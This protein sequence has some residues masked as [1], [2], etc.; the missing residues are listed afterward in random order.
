MTF[1]LEPDLDMVKMYLYTKNEVPSF[2][3]SKGIVWTDTQIDTQSDTQTN[4]Q[5]SLSEI[6]NY[7]HLW[8]VINPQVNLMTL[9][10]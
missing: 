8:M 1:I 3:S 7:L 2:S 10:G 4:T 6:I 5:T 9:K